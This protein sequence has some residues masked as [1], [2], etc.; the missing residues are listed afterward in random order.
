VECIPCGCCYRG[1]CSD[2]K[3]DVERG[4]NKEESNEDGGDEEGAEK[5]DG[6]NR[7]DDDS[8][9]VKGAFLFL[10]IP[11]LDTPPAELVGVVE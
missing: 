1:D 4:D 5:E 11:A 8:G 3:E 9:V 10:Q 6:E 2:K 7:K